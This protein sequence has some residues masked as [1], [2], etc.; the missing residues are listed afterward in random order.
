MGA[1]R[2]DGVCTLCEIGTHKNVTG[3]AECLMCPVN[4]TT[5][6]PGSTECGKSYAFINMIHC[7]LECTYRNLQLF[8]M[9]NLSYAK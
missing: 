6:E 9:G 2:Q 3:D 4:T 1:W 8:S 7:L 5:M